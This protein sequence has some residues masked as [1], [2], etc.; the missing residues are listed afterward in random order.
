VPVVVNL[1]YHPQLLTKT[2]RDIK[3]FVG[4]V[5]MKFQFLLQQCD[6]LPFLYILVHFQR[7][8]RFMGATRVV[9]ISL[10]VC[11]NG[12]LPNSH[13]FYHPSPSL[14]HKRG[15]VGTNKSL[16]K[17]GPCCS[18]AAFISIEQSF[19]HFTCPLLDFPCQ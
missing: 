6:C 17:L 3:F 4:F 10:L 2:S 16:H 5:S 9:G 12:R 15:N 19:I 13:E 7:F 14:S 8:K 18:F 11:C 1:F